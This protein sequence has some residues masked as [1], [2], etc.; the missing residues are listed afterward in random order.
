MNPRPARSP[1]PS[2]R[3]RLLAA[4]LPLTALA[5]ACGEASGPEGPTS[6][7][8]SAGRAPGDA[9]AAPTPE[10]VDSRFPK[11]TKG[12]KHRL[13][14]TTEEA[15]G[16]APAPR[17]PT[18]VFEDEAPL[19]SVE[20]S[21]GPVPPGEVK[22]GSAWSADYRHLGKVTLAEDGKLHVEI[23]GRVVGRH[24]QVSHNT[25]TF[26]P[27][28]SRWAYAFVQDGQT[29]VSLDGKE[30]GGYDGITTSRILFDPKGEHVAF[31]A[32]K[33]GKQFI[34]LDG[35]E[36]EKHDGVGPRGLIFSPEGSRWGYLARNGEKWSVVVDGKPGAAFDGITPAGVIFSH[37]GRRFAYTA[38]RGDKWLMVTNDEAGPEYDG[39]M[40]FVFADAGSRLAYITRNGKDAREYAWTIVSEGEETP[41]YDNLMRGA[42]VLSPDGAH[43]AYGAQ[44]GDEMVLI[45]DGEEK[46]RAPFGPDEAAA[47]R[48]PVFSDDGAHMAYSITRDGVEVVLLDGREIAT[49]HNVLGM[50]FSPD[51]GRLAIVTKD[52][53]GKLHIHVD[54]EASPP[55]DQITRESPAFSPDGTRMA[56][57]AGNG[58][59]YFVVVDGVPGKAY[60]Y[61]NSSSLAFTPDGEH[62]VYVAAKDDLNQFIV[63]DGLE[64][65]KR[66]D[67]VGKRADPLLVAP[68]RARLG[69][70]RNGEY[71]SV[72]V[73]IPT[74]GQ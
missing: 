55:Y 58:G 40:R 56:Y 13:G 61:V 2:S 6:N 68:D 15:A 67:Q 21:F 54:G 69:A 1:S 3:A 25:L 63:M 7:D 64:S 42:P 43:M 35:K 9:L 17:T 19:S 36:L 20:R 26:S 11:A 66:Y 51:G 46:V 53:N 28:G 29:F 37:D 41:P 23:D 24:D 62:V 10:E 50:K 38:Q 39:I 22:G 70:I 65:G 52:E 27:D 30:V 34:V 18:P 33:G 5:G 8:A 44:I 57:G 49:Y 4:L 74:D 31:T 48:L 16:P 73:S 47:F 72:E 32:Q 59:E 71:F 60:R 14:A 12:T 45:I